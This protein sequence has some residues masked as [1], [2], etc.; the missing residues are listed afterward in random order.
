M[1]KSILKNKVVLLFVN[2]FFSMISFSQTN[3]VGRWEVREPIGVR[4]M[5]EYSLVRQEKRVYG[6]ALILTQDGM[7]FNE[8]IVPCLNGSSVL[9]SGTY[10]LIDDYHIRFIVEDVHLQGLYAGMLEIK[11]SDIIKDLG[12]FYIYKEENSIRLIKSNGVLQ[13]DKDKML[14]TE[15]LK[16]F[17]K[18][19]KG[20]EYSWINT[21]ANI[22]EEVVK[23]YLS[24]KL[25]GLSDYKIVYSKKEAY[26][27]LF[28]VRKDEDFHYVLYNGI[29]QKVS[30]AY[31]R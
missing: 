14:Y 26:G 21:N 3:M 6:N 27:E 16:T 28:L 22:P 20:Y 19:W 9:P 13:D 30:L 15:M 8:D 25:I 24:N 17:D 2:L 5:E 10:T 11:T 31:P 1:S 4:D 7:F 23:D 12:V 18:N 29:K